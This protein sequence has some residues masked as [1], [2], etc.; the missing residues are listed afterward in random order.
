MNFGR[1]LK[2]RGTCFEGLSMNGFRSTISIPDPFVLSCVEGLGSFFNS[3]FGMCASRINRGPAR[4]RSQRC[5]RT[6]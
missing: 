1:L 6:S 5:G 2:N 4:E 3:G